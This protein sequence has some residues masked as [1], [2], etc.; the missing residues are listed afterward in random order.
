MDTVTQQQYAETFRTL[1]SRSDILILPNAW[2]VAS[3]L[4]FEQ[5]GFN[6]IG[7]S[8]AGIAASLGYPDG[9]QIS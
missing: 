6:A 2:D 5:A 7:T 9:E 4:L 1:H 8:S 3:A